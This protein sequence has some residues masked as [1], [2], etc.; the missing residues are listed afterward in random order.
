M[1][2]VA[3]IVRRVGNVCCNVCDSFILICF[4]IWATIKV[5]NTYKVDLEEAGLLTEEIGAESFVT[6][7]RV[8]VLMCYLFITFTCCCQPCITLFQ[9]EKAG[10]AQ[11]RAVRDRAEQYEA[12]DEPFL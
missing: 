3:T 2:D 5:T 1:L 10:R 7:A 11:R 12:L 6:M 9:V 8:N 4:V